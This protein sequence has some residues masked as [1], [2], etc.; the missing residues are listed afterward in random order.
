MENGDRN[1][2]FCPGYKKYLK[3]KK[4]TILVANIQYSMHA[5]TAHAQLPEIGICIYK[6]QNF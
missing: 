2:V 3:K 5:C 6:I 1:D 4:I